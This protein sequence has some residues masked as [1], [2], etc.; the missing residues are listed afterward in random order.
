MQNG[1]ETKAMYFNRFNVDYFVSVGRISH[2]HIVGFIR[3]SSAENRT[4][5]C[6]F[7]FYFVI[8]HAEYDAV[9]CC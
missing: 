4:F 8:Y 9:S 2:L 3:S 5:L 6:F 7:F 1:R